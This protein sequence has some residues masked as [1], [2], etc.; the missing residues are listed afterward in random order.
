MVVKQ[1]KIKI[2]EVIKKKLIF[3]CSLALK[4]LFLHDNNLLLA[5]YGQCILKSLKI[6]YYINIYIKIYFDV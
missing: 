4:T 1:I 3:T 5:I 6:I 2:I